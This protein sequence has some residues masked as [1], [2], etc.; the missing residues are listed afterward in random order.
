M[1]AFISIK[2]MEE[3]NQKLV[4]E[5][6][7]ALQQNGIEAFCFVRDI[8]KYGKV[9]FKPENLMSKALE[10][11]KNSDLLIV[12]LTEKGVGIGIEAGY[13]HAMNIPIITIAQKGSDISTTLRGISKK[14]AFYDNP[15]DLVK[16]FKNIT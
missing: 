11:I 7:E 4:T 1:R 5:I 13:A 3:R 16:I 8:E 6:S 14:V 10:Y 15:E 2:F 9:K 12:E